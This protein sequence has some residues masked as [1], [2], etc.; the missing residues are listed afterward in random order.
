MFKVEEL[1]E[2]QIAMGAGGH[3]GKVS[4]A[5]TDKI[6]QL[7]TQVSSHSYCE[8][9]KWFV[10]GNNPSAYREVVGFNP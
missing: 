3:P 2:N 10:K 4:S 9:Q 8:Y 7:E 6:A 5:V 1:Q